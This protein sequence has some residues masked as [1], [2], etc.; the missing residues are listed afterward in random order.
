MYAGF[1][2]E[3]PSYDMRIDATPVAELRAY[4]DQLREV[5]ANVAERAPTHADFVARVAGVDAVG[6]HP[7]RITTVNGGGRQNPGGCS[8]RFP[9]AIVA[10]ILLTS[11][12]SSLADTAQSFAVHSP[13]R[14]IVVSVAATQDGPPTYSIA[15]KGEVV[16]APSQLR[17]QLQHDRAFY[18]FEAVSSQAR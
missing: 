5:I 17:L 10:V 16:I 12:N 9:A 2:I 13:D 15:R 6:A 1:G 8:V 14:H 11:T 4:L 18:S 3:P 7:E